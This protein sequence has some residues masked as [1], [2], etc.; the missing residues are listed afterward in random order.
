[1]ATAA[2]GLLLAA[3]AG[4]PSPT[5][6]PDPQLDRTLEKLDQPAP[7][8][9]RLEQRPSPTSPLST[10]VSPPPPTPR[11]SLT[12]PPD[13]GPASLPSPTPNPSNSSWV[14][15]RL[16]AIVSLYNVTDAGAA[17]IESLD[18]RQT[19]GDPGF[20]GS[21]GFKA[22]AGVGEAKPIG[23]VHEISHSYWGGFPVD[24]LPQLSWDRPPG[25]SLS[26]AMQRY[27][28]DILAFMAQPPDD[29]ELLRQRLRNLPDLSKD[30]QEPL[31]H[32]MEADLVYNTGGNLALVPPILRKYWRQFL[33]GGPFDSWYGA[34]AWYRS[35]SGENRKSVNQYLGFEHLDLRRYGSLTFSGQGN[36]LIE[37]RRDTLAQEER[38]RLYDLAD[39]F[40]L[41][42]G[43]SQKE[44]DFD[45]WRSYLRDK[46]GLH[47]SHPDYLA[48]LELRRALALASALGFLA[49]PDSI[50]ATA[51]QAAQIGERLASEPFLVN[52]LPA[53]DN[54]VLLALLSGETPL[55]RGTML[56]ATASFVERLDR[57]SRTVD[58]ILASSRDD[59]QRAGSQLQDFLQGIDFGPEDDLKLFF[60]LLRDA[61][62]ELAGRVV[63]ALDSGT[64]RRLMG[65]VPF[66]LRTILTPGELL[67]KLGV[68]AHGKVDDLK[69]GISLLVEE[70]SG[71]FIVDEPFLDGML[72]VIAG[73]SGREP[74]GTAQVLED[75]PFPLERFIQQQP[76]A[77]VGLLGSDLEAAV[78]LVLGSDPVLSP[79]ARIIYRLIGAGPELAAR[80]TQALEENGDNQLVVESLAYMAYDK[81]RAERVPSLEISLEQDG[82][83]LSA[84]LSRWGTEGLARRLGEAFDLFGERAAA[85]EVSADF[86]AHYRDTLEAAAATVADPAVSNQLRRAITLAAAEHAAGS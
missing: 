33:R 67:G 34:I 22:W 14:R 79:P 39:Q 81:S 12:D 80:L 82:R 63:L 10:G 71:N 62:P 61:D 55:P 43:D 18:V 41:L 4:G 75:T 44:E 72:A 31:F 37:A 52:F 51:E 74:G 32:N 11:S 66:H 2:L 86:L 50:G 47:R 73:R 78:R 70:P 15:Q 13:S 23:V 16:Q 65:P 64:I 59:P 17:L 7:A 35:L 1:M 5:A 9:G 20:F 8:V 54:R 53:L 21:Y 46:A 42:L 85:N 45:F 84:L 36:A 27:H 60:E 19:R 68:T 77:A 48:S 49:S 3:C 25:Q 24:G 30:N 29:Y 6:T 76:Q 58:G 57:F 83:F 56:R 38:Q 26:P 69:Q 28:A 40:D